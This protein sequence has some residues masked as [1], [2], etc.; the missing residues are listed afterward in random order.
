[1][2]FALIGLFRA[3]AEADRERIHEQFNSHLAQPFRHVRLGGSL[4][5]GAGRRTGVL[6]V[7]E[8]DTLEQAQAFLDASPYVRAGLYERVELHRL[9]VEVGRIA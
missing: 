8:A 5:D 9:D 4:K 7:V 1:M 6:L 3:D 2:L